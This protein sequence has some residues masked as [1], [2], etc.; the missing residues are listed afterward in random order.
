MERADGHSTMLRHTVDARVNAHA[1]LGMSYIYLVKVFQPLD[2]P[3][4]FFLNDPPPPEIYT[5]PLHDALPISPSAAASRANSAKYC[6][7]DFGYTM[8]SPSRLGKPALGMP[9]VRLSSTAASSCKIGSSA[10]GPSVQ[11]APITCTFLLFSCAA[12]SEGRMSPWVVPSS[13]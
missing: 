6:G 4:F 12:A 10:C 3:F 9:L 8:R 5:F 11:F 13:E 7:D 1:A 2:Y